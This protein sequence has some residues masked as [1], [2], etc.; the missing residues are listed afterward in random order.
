MT[1]ISHCI[2]YDTLNI[3]TGYECFWVKLFGDYSITMVVEMLFRQ[4][5]SQPRGHSKALGGAQMVTTRAHKQKLY[6]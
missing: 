1:I 6:R 5:V 2:L 4:S 3:I